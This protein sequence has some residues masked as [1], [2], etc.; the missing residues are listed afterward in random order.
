MRGDEPNILGFM[1]YLFSICPTCVGMNQVIWLQRYIMRLHLPHVRGDEPPWI[2][3][4][5]SH[6]MICPTCVGMNREGELEAAIAEAICPTCVGMNRRATPL[7]F[8]R[9]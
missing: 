7:E 5:P 2:F 4:S 6:L 8:T 1:L 9:S 3:S